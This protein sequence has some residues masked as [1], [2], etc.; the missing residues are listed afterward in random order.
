MAA[1][2]KDGA[3][4]A[5]DVCTPPWLPWASPKLGTLSM[6]S[7]GRPRPRSSSALSCL[8]C[9]SSPAILNCL[10]VGCSIL[11]SMG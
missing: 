4:H 8:R 7:P 6:D 2:T 10:T 11:S 5:G 3:T 1:E 9:S